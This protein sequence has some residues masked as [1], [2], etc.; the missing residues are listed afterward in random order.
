M[1]ARGTRSV[2]CGFRGIVI[3]IWSMFSFSFFLFLFLSCSSLIGNTFL[4]IDIGGY[5]PALKLFFF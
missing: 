1:D 4:I 2:R 5:R 3:G